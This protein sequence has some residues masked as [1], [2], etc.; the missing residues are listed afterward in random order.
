MKSLV[1]P[2]SGMQL[3]RD[4]FAGFGVSLVNPGK[5]L[6]RKPLGN[7]H[8]GRPQPLVNVGDLPFNEPADQHVWTVSDSAGQSKYFTTTFM[9]PPATS[10]R[11]A[12]DSGR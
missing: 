10:N 1:A 6:E 8:Q 12:G 5:V 3:V 7:T 2:S 9:R 4:V 11:A